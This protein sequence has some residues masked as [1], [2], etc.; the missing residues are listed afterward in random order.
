MNWVIIKDMKV[1]VGFSSSLILGLIAISLAQ[2]NNYAVLF[3]ILAQAVT[4][5]SVSRA[6]KLTHREDCVKTPMKVWVT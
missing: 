5:I 4:A 2:Y 3:I 1:A 6:S